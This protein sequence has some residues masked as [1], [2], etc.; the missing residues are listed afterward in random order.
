[1]LQSYQ[2]FIIVSTFHIIGKYV[3]Y[4]K[5]RSCVMLLSELVGNVAYIKL[6]E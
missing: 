6:I 1:M 2:S 5:K 4:M 3:S